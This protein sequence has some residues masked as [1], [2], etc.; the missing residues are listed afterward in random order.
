MSSAIVKSATSVRLLQ[1]RIWLYA[2][3]KSMG[4]PWES[5][6]SMD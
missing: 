1:V 3:V 2:R 5:I 6:M 4:Y